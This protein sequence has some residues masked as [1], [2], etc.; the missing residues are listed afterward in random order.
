M[1]HA[2]IFVDDCEEGLIKFEKSGDMDESTQILD[3]MSLHDF[4]VPD[5]L[6][7]EA[8]APV[9]P[10]AK[11]NDFF[12]NI[13]FFEHFDSNVLLFRYVNSTKNNFREVGTYDNKKIV[14][15]D[16]VLLVGL[17]PSIPI[18]DV[19]NSLELNESQIQRIHIFKRRSY[20][21]ST[22]FAFYLYLTI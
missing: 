3:G 12:G 13:I 18:I 20:L 6:D 8:V 1:F 15:M 16:T 9:V 22:G 14:P 11:L 19:L 7:E 4:G 17:C 21:G 2:A 10:V 5:R